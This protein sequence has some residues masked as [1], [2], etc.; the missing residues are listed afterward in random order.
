MR[1]KD[2]YPGG[3]SRWEEFMVGELALR[4][5]VLHARA[6]RTGGRHLGTFMF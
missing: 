6:L 3:S 1:F 5:W 2:K 4:G